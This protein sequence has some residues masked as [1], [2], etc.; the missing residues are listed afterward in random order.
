MIR[1]DLTIYSE[2]ASEWWE[3]GAPRFRSLQ[4]LTPFRLELIST[5]LG[6]QQ[7]KAVLD[8]GCG[9]GLIAKPLIEQGAVVA[10]I[11]LSAESIAAA[12]AAC[13][14]R[15]D[16][17]VGDARE[18]PFATQSFDTVLMA[19]LLDHIPD[20]S[21]ALAEAARVLKPGGM[22]FVG[23]I[24]RS[25]WSAFV[26]VTVAESLRLIPPGT[27]DPKLF[28]KPE[29]LVSS[30]KAHGLTLA[31]LQGEA[32]LFWKTLLNWAIYLRRSRSLAVA[33]SAVFKK[34]ELQ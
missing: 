22:L 28:I 18:V 10:G 34:R 8:I 31:A 33:Y 25:L 16:F 9:G 21:K 7:G 12:R 14:G 32:P 4:A 19:D 27:H 30:A 3:P 17:R 26:T 13:A 1:N 2:Y 11:D 23:T 20:Y 6:P 15:G 5:L 24:N 29:E